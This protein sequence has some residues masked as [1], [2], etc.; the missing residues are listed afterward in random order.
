CADNGWHVHLTDRPDRI[1]ATIAALEAT[2]VRVVVDHMGMI[3]TPAG[4]E[5]PGFRAI[6]K[7]VDRGRTWLKLSGAFRYKSPEN[8]C[9]AARALVSAAGWNR[10]MWGSDWPFVGYM[11]KVTYRDTLRYLEWVEDRTMRS[12]VAAETALD[13]YF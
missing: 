10:L 3:D 1:G 2:G 5:D 11:G 7:A 4:I 6:L 9:A 8:A 12:R 13:F